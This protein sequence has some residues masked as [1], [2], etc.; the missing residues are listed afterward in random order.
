LQYA[1]DRQVLGLSKIQCLINEWQRGMS[2]YGISPVLVQVSATSVIDRSLALNPV[3]HP[4]V[5][6][7]EV[8]VLTVAIVR[9]DLA[10]HLVGEVVQIDSV[11][12]HTG[13]VAHPVAAPPVAVV[14]C[15]VEQGQDFLAQVKGHIGLKEAGLKAVH[16]K[17]MAHGVLSV[18]SA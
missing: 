1:I 2:T 18:L 7:V 13:S 11:V 17:A 4:E 3:I 12:V 16:Y 6:P 15:S 5:D 10:V 14:Q 9:R 8:A